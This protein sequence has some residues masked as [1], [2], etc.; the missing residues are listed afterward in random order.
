[1]WERNNWKVI[2]GNNIEKED[3]GVFKWNQ[4]TVNVIKRCVLFR[5]TT[6][7]NPIFR[8]NL[9]CQNWKCLTVAMCGNFMKVFPCGRQT[10]NVALRDFSFQ[11]PPLVGIGLVWYLV[12]VEWIRIIWNLLHWCLNIELLYYNGTTHIYSQIR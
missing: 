11:Y 12:G 4:E 5:D 6:I 2:A 9:I 8:C 1:M 10:A 3:N 7:I